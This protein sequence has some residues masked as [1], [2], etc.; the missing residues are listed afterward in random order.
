M[1][2]GIKIKKLVLAILLST[3]ASPAW[4]TT[5]YLATAAGGGS[6]SNKGTSEGTPW[7]TPKHAVNCGDVILAAP[8]TAYVAANFHGPN[9]GTVSCPA[10]NNVAWLKCAIFDTCKIIVTDGSTYGMTVSQ[11]YWGV[12]GWEVTITKDSGAGAGCFT[13]S[14]Y[15]VSYAQVSHVIFANNIANIC[16]GG[17]GFITGHG[18]SKTVGID[19]VAMIGNIVYN[20]SGGSAASGPGCYSGIDFYNPGPQSDALPGTHFYAA[21]NFSWGNFDANPCDGGNPSDGEGILIDRPDSSGLSFPPY[22]QQIVID[23]NIVIANGGRGIE[24]YLNSAGSA[25]APIYFRH[26][27]V[28]GNNLDTRNTVAAD[29]AETIVSHALNT[30][31]FANI[32]A[33]SAATGCLGSYPIHAYYVDTGDSTD[34]V[35][36]NVGWST[37]GKHS[38]SATSTGFSYGPNNLFGTNPSFANAVAPEPPNCE[39]ATSVPDCMA[40]V[41]A[42]FTPT[43]ASAV[44]YGYQKPSTTQTYDPLFPQWL[45]NVNLP[46]GLVTMGCLA[47]PSSPASPTKLSAKVH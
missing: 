7:L 11:S 28:W 46:A 15:Y 45:C 16:A 19:Y 24:V 6:D 36:N 27:T 22:T 33:T 34:R 37:D 17:G 25:H 3:L 2:E 31:V 9:W 39:S 43:N 40:K 14:P 26:N 10:G 42:N 32:T 12:Q 38:G 5:Y 35:D 47:Q 41:I 21:G 30:Q 23:N 44:G 4:A 1:L 29:C 18:G 8:S 20:A 13:A